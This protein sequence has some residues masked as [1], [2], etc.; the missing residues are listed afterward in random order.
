MTVEMATNRAKEILKNRS[1]ARLIE[2]FEATEGNQDENIPMVRSF[3]MDELEARNPSGFEAW[4]DSTAVSP[5]SF[6]L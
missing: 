2:D 3:L 6:F 4:L 5:R 1:M